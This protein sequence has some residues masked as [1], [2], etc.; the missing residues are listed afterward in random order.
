MIEASEVPKRLEATICLE[1]ISAFTGYLS[2]CY[3]GA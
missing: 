2:R 3:F 1:V